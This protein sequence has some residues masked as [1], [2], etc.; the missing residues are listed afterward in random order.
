[1]TVFRL[2]EGFTIGALGEV[3]ERLLEALARHKGVELD[4]TSVREVDV[5]ALQ[6][7]CAAR[8]QAAL[9]G[10]AIAF[11]PDGRGRVI[12]GAM[13]AI[14]LVRTAACEA[15]CLCVGGPLG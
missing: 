9:A 3:R 8:R 12:E 13:V 4:C 7:L 11:T 6:I 2:P 5:A 10:K 14:G 1:M 15:G